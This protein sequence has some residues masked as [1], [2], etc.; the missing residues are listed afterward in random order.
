MRRAL[1]SLYAAGAVLGGL[2]LLGIVFLVVVQAVSRWLAAPLAGTPELAGYAM[3]NG[4]FLPFGYAFR[5]AAHIRISLVV[6]R[7]SGNARQA[8]ELICLLVG[9][10][11]ASYMAFYMCRMA[12]FS[13]QIGDISQGADATPLWIPQAGLALG[14]IVFAV[15][16]ADSLIECIAAFRRSVSTTVQSTASTR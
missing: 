15:A 13:L 6:D 11:L 14:A 8:A 7:L 3:I 2:C 10:G 12:L 1:D 9:F 4:F 5:K 16:V